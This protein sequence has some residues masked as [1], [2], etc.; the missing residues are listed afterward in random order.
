MSC[1]LSSCL[2]YIVVW[3]VQTPLCKPELH[4]HT[5]T[6]T[7]P[8]STIFF[9]L[10][11]NTIVLWFM[12]SALG[13]LLI[14]LF[15]SSLVHCSTVISYSIICLQLHW[16]LFC[17]CTTLSVVPLSVYLLHLLYCL[18]FI[19]SKLV[20]RVYVNLW[21]PLERRETAFRFLCMSLLH[22]ACVA[23]C[24]YDIVHKVLDTFLSFWK[25]KLSAYPIINSTLNIIMRGYTRHLLVFICLYIC[26][27]TYLSIYSCVS[28]SH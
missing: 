25:N 15:V 21:L 4:R 20:C 13:N 11:I 10:H 26:L 7:L 27:S 18:Y 5:S 28:C 24:M 8:S 12:W 6:Q 22:C 16:H 19:L 3:F 9:F 1:T 23:V 17:F 2:C 14:S